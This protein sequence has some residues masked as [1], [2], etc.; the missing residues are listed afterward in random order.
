MHSKRLP[1]L[2]EAAPK[3]ISIALQQISSYSSNMSFFRTHAAN[4][5]TL[6]APLGG[7]LLCG[8][9]ALILLR[10]RAE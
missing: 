7:L 2:F 10:S 3:N 8:L 6:S 5:N 9:I 4:A 1:C